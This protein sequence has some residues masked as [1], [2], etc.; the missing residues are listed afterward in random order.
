VRLAVGFGLSDARPACRLH[1]K[2]RLLRFTS[3]FPTLVHARE[4]RF[5][6]ADEVWRC[7][8]TLRVMAMCSCWFF[9]APTVREGPQSPD[10]L[11]RA[12]QGSRDNGWDVGP[13]KRR[14]EHT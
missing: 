3:G 8:H 13:A 7:G 5:V 4:S 11:V 12:Q 9:R 14:H 1:P 6:S 10:Y 2:N